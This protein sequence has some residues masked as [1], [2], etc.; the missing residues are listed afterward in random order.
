MGIF[1]FGKSAIPIGLDIGTGH[2]RAA[3]LS[4]GNPNPM[5]TNY[6]TIKVPVGSVVEGEVVDIETASQSLVQLWKKSGLP[7]KDVAVGIASQKV[8]VRLIELPFMEKSELKNA[9][10]YQAQDY[11]PIPVEEAIIDAQIVS[12]FLSENE[13]K[14]MEVLLV[15]AQKDL[16]NNTI[17]AIEG[18]GLRPQVVDLSA[19][20]IVRSLLDDQDSFFS[21]E[22]ERAPGEATALI[23]IGSGLTN[24]VVVEQGMPRFARVTPMAGDDL[25]RAIADAIGVPFEEAEELKQAVGLPAVDSQE[26]GAEAPA[27]A[28][29]SQAQVV[30]HVLETQISYFVA[31]IRRSID[32]YLTQATQVRNISRLI[33]SG[34]GASL[35][36]IA[37]YLERGLQATVEISNPLARVKISPKL[38]AEALTKEEHSMAIPIGLALRGFN[39]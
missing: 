3:Q 21:A 18:A 1:S 35:A 27:D 17:A 7:G 20:A 29:R 6:A 33:L 24:I 37:A 5:L 4:P 2:F 28:D 16:V 38:S 23:N 32:Y 8:V 31:E 39:K 14:M 25:T 34:N 10:Q 9:I 22:S 36:N 13:E 12:Q 11:I 30:Q 19:F 15:A 26:S